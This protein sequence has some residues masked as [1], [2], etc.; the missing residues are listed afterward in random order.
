MREALEEEYHIAVRWADDRARNTRENASQA[1]KLLGAEGKRKVVLVLHGFDV[2]R[3][4]RAFED[5]GLQVV[6]APTHVPRWDG[7]ELQ[8]LLPDA[9]ALVTTHYALYEALALV[10]DRLGT[11]VGGR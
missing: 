3:A 1:A 8:S 2:R 11:L 9:R 4:R 6:A 5:A 7:I 10:R